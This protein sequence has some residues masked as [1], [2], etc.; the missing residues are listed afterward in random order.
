MPVPLLI[1]IAMT[2]ARQ[3]L[4]SLV[5][6][7]AG[8]NA[9]KIAEQIV[10]HAKNVTGEDD[11]QKAMESLQGNPEFVLQYREKLIDLQA[12][13]LEED[14][15]RLKAVNKTM[16]KEANS[17]DSF[18]RRWRPFYGYCVA[19]SWFI[20]MT[21][22]SFALAYTIIKNPAQLPTIIT[23]LASVFTALAG[24]WGIALTVLGVSVHQRSKDK[25]I[26]AGHPSGPG[27]LAQLL[28]K[29]KGG[30]DV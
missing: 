28:P 22:F 1:P 10:G 14:T 24:L 27:M 23:A 2:L 30:K 3:F 29:L 18:V 11:P 9:E 4:P 21:L 17:T 26:A 8:D 6:K 5:G 25:Q 20:Q 16:Q 7:L 13:E 15:K 12:K 19:I